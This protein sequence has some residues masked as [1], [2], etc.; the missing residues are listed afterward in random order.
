MKQQG[1]DWM[2]CFVINLDR[3]PERAVHIA[4]EF[5]AHGI[6][7]ERFPAADGREALE[8]RSLLSEVVSASKGRRRNWAAGEIG[9]LVSHYRVWQK[10]AAEVPPEG[11][12]AVFEDDVLLA[13]SVA[14]LLDA[15]EHRLEGADIVK[16]DALPEFAEYDM[17]Y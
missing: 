12:A 8:E 17:A 11:R 13:N 16:L 15:L 2:R 9:C 14:P 10:I 4:T 3:A 1:K 5:A 7:Y 6:P